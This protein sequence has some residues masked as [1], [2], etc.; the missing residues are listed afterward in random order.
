MT[1]CSVRGCHE[2]GTTTW[3]LIPGEPSLCGHH[4]DHPT[5]QFADLVAAANAPPDDFDI[6]DDW[7]ELPPPLPRY[8]MAAK[9][10]WVTKE[11]RVIS[12]RELE[13]SHLRNID[14]ML[15]RIEGKMD[16]TMDEETGAPMGDGMPSH[17]QEMFSRKQRAIKHEMARR[18]LHEKV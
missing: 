12:I 8:L 16:D 6:L 18:E 17:V 9:D 5:P 7:V 10:T 2:E 14:R 11:G 15:R 4:Y 3:P 1:E 13:D